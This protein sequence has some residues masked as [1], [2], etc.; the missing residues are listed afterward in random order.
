MEPIDKHVWHQL[1]LE[2]GLVTMVTKL[3]PSCSHAD[4]YKFCIHIRS[5]NV[6]HFRIVKVKGIKN[7]GVEVNF[8]GRSVLLN[9]MKIYPIAPKL[10][11]GDTEADRRTHTGDLI[12]LI[13]II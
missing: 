9:F 1:S 4:W 12:N 3:N 7:Y 10:L 2:N 6:R 13:F 11:V 5:M 8:N